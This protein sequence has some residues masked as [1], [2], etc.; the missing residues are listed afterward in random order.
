MIRLLPPLLEGVDAS[1]DGVCTVEKKCASGRDRWGK[2][3]RSV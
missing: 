1:V 3:S 2:H